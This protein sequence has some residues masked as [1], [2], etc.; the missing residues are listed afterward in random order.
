MALEWPRRADV[1]PVPHGPIT[2][3]RAVP[4]WLVDVGGGVGGASGD[5]L[6]VSA[7]VEEDDDAPD[8]LLALLDALLFAAEVVVDK[9]AVVLVA[10]AAEASGEREWE[11]LPTA[12]C[13]VERERMR[14]EQEASRRLIDAL[15]AAIWRV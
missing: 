2:D 6:D 1:S 5:V 15:T 8:R 14:R 7:V 3:A 4:A 9:V 12:F 13:T 10:A 11:L